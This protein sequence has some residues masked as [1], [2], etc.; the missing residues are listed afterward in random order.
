VA[1]CPPIECCTADDFE[2]ARN[3]QNEWTELAK[4][5]EGLIKDSRVSLASCLYVVLKG[6]ETKETSFPPPPPPSSPGVQ[7]PITADII[8]AYECPI[9]KG[10]FQDV[11]NMFQSSKAHDWFQRL[12]RDENAAEQAFGCFKTLEANFIVGIMLFKKLKKI[13]REL[14]DKK[15]LTAAEVSELTY[16]CWVLFLILS[17]HM[18]QEGKCMDIFPCFK[19]LVACLRATLLCVLPKVSAGGS[20]A[21]R[22]EDKQT[23]SN[24]IMQTACL[25][26]DVV[27][28]LGREVEEIEEATE[29]LLESES[30][31]EG[32][33]LK[34]WIKL[35][36]KTLTAHLALQPLNL[37]DCRLLALR[38]DL[39]DI[40]PSQASG[41]AG[42]NSDQDVSDARTVSSNAPSSPSKAQS[43]H[44]E[45]RTSSDPIFRTPERPVKHA[46]MSDPPPTPVSQ[47]QEDHVWFS[48]FLMGE[49]V[50][51]DAR[52][53]GF[54]EACTPPAGEK[55]R[56]SLAMLMDKLGM[57]KEQRDLATRMC[58]KILRTICMREEERKKLSSL[59]VMLHEEALLKGIVAF[60]CEIVSFLNFSSSL[61]LSFI[62]EKVD[63]SEFELLVFIE[64]FLYLMEV[65]KFRLSYGINHH[66][67]DIQNRIVESEGWKRGSPLLRY[68]QKEELAEAF[69]R[70]LNDFNQNKHSV[71]ESPMRVSAH[72][73]SSKKQEVANSAAAQEA[74]ALQIR[75]SERQLSA[76]AGRLWV[77]AVEVLEC[78][79]RHLRSSGM[80]SKSFNRAYAVMKRILETPSARTL[81]IDRNLHQIILCVLFGACKSEGELNVTFKVLVCQHKAA[82]NTQDSDRLYWNVLLDENKLGNIIEFYNQ[83]I[84]PTCKEFVQ[85]DIHDFSSTTPPSSPFSVK[86]Y[87][88]RNVTISPMLQDRV[89]SISMSPRTNRLMTYESSN[90]VLREE[91]DEASKRNKRQKPM[92]KDVER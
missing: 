38:E 13:M 23:L 49:G 82:Y 45:A 60:T 51:P 22:K 42:S 54:L 21:R 27:D 56:K 41:R 92:E 81:M 37:L 24:Q 35:L 69:A 7:V 9:L 15:F 20:F 91:E 70:S 63:I 67:R 80:T 28:L 12:F 88:R 31:W 43:L 14:K 89:I 10:F 32:R 33:G 85:S 84:V 6:R 73:S 30:S 59:S 36:D 83:K 4:K 8:Q 44:G 71:P 29:K 18:M 52:L 1:R 2:A 66:V 76:F 17:R 68:L 55:I 48:R 47:A 78:M 79:Y 58:W 26:G 61:H 87:V 25:T 77:R 72:R 64:N 39:V 34:E 5:D 57:Q 50:E 3:L 75:V 11:T 40:E 65:K 16:P 90:G 86:K 62:L 53:T 74:E 19:M 46:K